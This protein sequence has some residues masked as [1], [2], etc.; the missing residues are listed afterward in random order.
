MNQV[1]ILNTNNSKYK[2]QKGNKG[3]YFRSHNLLKANN[4]FLLNNSA[5]IKKS[6]LN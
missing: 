1:V 6:H 2:T 3:G 5:E 4:E